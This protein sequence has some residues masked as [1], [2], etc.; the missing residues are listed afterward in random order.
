MPDLVSLSPRLPSSLITMHSGMDYSKEL[1]FARIKPW[2]TLRAVYEPVGSSMQ[3]IAFGIYSFNLGQ[4][5][6]ASLKSAWDDT[7]EF[8]VYLGLSDYT[9]GRWKWFSSSNDNPLPL[10]DA[11]RYCRED[12]LCLV[13]LVLTG[14]QPHRLNSIG[15]TSAALYDE[16]EPN[17]SFEEAE[18]LPALPVYAF[19]GSVGSRQSAAGYDG[20][21]RDYFRINAATGERFSV[22]ALATGPQNSA[23]HLQLELYGGEYKLQE[24][25]S[26]L[27]GVAALEN[28]LIQAGY[29]PYY[30]VLHANCADYELYLVPGAGGMLPQV[31]L[32]ASPDRGVPPLAVTLD[33][34]ASSDPNPTGSIIRYDWDFEGDGIWDLQE[35]AEPVIEHVY[36]SEG[37][38]YPRVRVGNELGLGRQDAWY[39]LRPGVQTVTVGAS[40]SDEVEDNDGPTAENANSLTAIPFTGFIGNVGHAYWLPGQQY[41]GDWAD[42]F[43]FDAQAGLPHSFFDQNYSAN[44]APGYYPKNVRLS[45][46]EL[47]GTALLSGG[48]GELRNITFFPPMNGQYLLKVGAGSNSELR[49]YS[50]GALHKYPPHIS[51]LSADPS[52]GVAPYATTISVAAEDEDSDALSYAWS[53]FSIFPQPELG[54]LPTLQIIA[55][56]QGWNE[57]T[58]FVTDETG[59]RSNRTIVIYGWPHEY[60]ELEPNDWWGAAQALP[61]LPVINFQGSLGGLGRGYDG[62]TTDV[63]H[64]PHTLVNG[65]TF[66]IALTHDNPEKEFDLCVCTAFGEVLQQV[67]TAGGEAVHEYTAANGEPQP[68]RIMLVDP[69]EEY[70]PHFNYSLQVELTE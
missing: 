4:L 26:D 51:A 28:I 14:E 59:L 31:D 25:E 18:L 53:R 24:V 20:K 16:L 49:E 66:T 46:H 6:S 60:Q 7:D 29:A 43:V 27:E 52:I 64:L 61:Q 5:Q 36:E 3:T 37:V 10:P 58:C 15:F 40:P 9:A 30:L 1:P 39:T 11:N 34:S 67:A 35:G 50:L 70:L 45:I 38:F 32:Q 42:Y 21:P 54:T 22:Y 33:A 48:N 2:D 17:N 41:D 13:A 56:W 55:D 69:S 44:P 8:T 12:G 65:T 23:G 62:G 57:V 47:D 63:F 68:Y 19:R